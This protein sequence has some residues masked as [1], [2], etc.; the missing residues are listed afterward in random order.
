M[1]DAQ[2]NP[3]G[4]IYDG[5]TGKPVYVPLTQEEDKPDPI[6]KL[7]NTLEIN[8]LNLTS[9]VIGLARRI[10]GLP[11]RD[12]QGNG[13]TDDEVGLSI[14]L[15]VISHRIL[16]RTDAVPEFIGNLPAALGGGIDKVASFVPG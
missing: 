2:G 3:D 8:N 10:Y 6:S 4:T 7:L 13:Y 16:Y 9:N 14:M 12:V 1:T 5:M 15:T 11:E